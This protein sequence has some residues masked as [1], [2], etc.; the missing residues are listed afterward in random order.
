MKPQVK[1]L[2]VRVLIG[3][4]LLGMLFLP[5]LVFEPSLTA[6]IQ[7]GFPVLARSGNQ[8]SYA[9]FIGSLTG[10]GTPCLDG[11][12]NLTV[13]GCPGGTSQ[14]HSITFVIDGGGS[15]ITTGDIK[16]YP[17]AEFSC[18]INQATISA[19]QSGSITVDIWKVNAAIPTSGNKI[20]ASAPV[21]LSAS[22]LNQASSLAGWTLGVVAN[23]VFG[24][25]VATASTV[26]RVVGQL[27]CQ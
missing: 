14:L 7:S 17:S 2:F 23:D 24:F 1:K 15:A 4:F 9:N 3:V 12:G 5:A 18:T 16:V 25:N 8:N 11:S 6:S 27:W 21:T 20:S 19:D 13:S 10:T 26:T 22:Q